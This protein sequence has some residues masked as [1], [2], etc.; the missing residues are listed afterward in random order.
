[1]GRVVIFGARL[2]DSVDQDGCELDILVTKKRNKKAAMKFF[3]KLFGA[4]FQQPCGTM[5]DKLRRYKA[6]L[7]DLNCEPPHISERYENNIAELPH[8]KT[9]H[10]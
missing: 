7:G 6:A 2:R 3:K 9:R 10:L 8:Q 4:Q 5:T 1:M